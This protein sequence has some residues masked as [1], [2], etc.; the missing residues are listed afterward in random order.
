MFFFCSW[1][2]FAPSPPLRRACPLGPAGLPNEGE[3]NVK[4]IEII[5]AAGIALVAILLRYYYGV[6]TVITVTVH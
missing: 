1:R 6:I 3:R 2:R 4:K 5:A